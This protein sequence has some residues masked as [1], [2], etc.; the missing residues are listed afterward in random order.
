MWL[1][2]RCWGRTELAWTNIQLKILFF[3]LLHLIEYTAQEGKWAAPHL[4]YHLCGKR[5]DHLLL[6][7]WSIPW[8]GG[9]SAQMCWYVF[10]VIY[11]NDFDCDLSSDSPGQAGNSAHIERKTTSS[12]PA[13]RKKQNQNISVM[14]NPTK[15]AHIPQIWEPKTHLCLEGENWV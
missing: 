5:K 3:Y 13:C 1:R 12:K 4:G 6:W 7:D 10:L 8:E 9:L 14:M 2:H 15:Q 11:Q